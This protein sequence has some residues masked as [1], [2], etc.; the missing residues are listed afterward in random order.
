M[1]DLYCIS[2]YSVIDPS[3]TF[4]LGLVPAAFDVL[5]VSLTGR[6]GGEIIL[7]G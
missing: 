3:E 2:V 5:R 7:V 6:G 4:I 1:H